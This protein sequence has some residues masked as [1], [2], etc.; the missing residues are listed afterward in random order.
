[1]AGPDDVINAMTQAAT[2]ET[3]ATNAQNSGNT[4]LNTDA[5][6]LAVL[7]AQYQN[8]YVPKCG[9][10]SEIEDAIA[11]A[12]ASLNAATNAL[13]LAHSYSGFSDTSYS[14]GT[15]HFQQQSY[16]QAVSDYNTATTW[17]NK[18]SSKAAFAA[19]EERSA[20]AALTEIAHL[21]NQ[22]GA[23]FSSDSSDSSTN[24]SSNSSGMSSSL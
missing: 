18:A 3:N 8:Q 17:A 5:K 24:S 10:N 2:A 22:C 11:S 7:Q 20:E 6:T 9:T 1:M 13:G 21:I 12:L 23:G 15:L 16:C 19:C 14:L 4:A